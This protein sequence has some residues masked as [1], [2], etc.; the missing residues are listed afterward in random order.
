MIPIVVRISTAELLENP[1]CF[2]M[3]EIMQQMTAIPKAMRIP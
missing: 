3:M 2:K 1:N